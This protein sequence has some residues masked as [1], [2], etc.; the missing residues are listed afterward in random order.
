MLRKSILAF[1]FI[2]LIFCSCKG[3]KTAT[4]PDVSPHAVET[5]TTTGQPKGETMSMTVTSTAFAERQPI[6]TK[7]TGDAEDMSPALAWTAGPAG[8]RTYAIICD[9]PDAPTPQPWVHWVMYDIPADVTSL[10]EAVPMTATLPFGAVQGRS[11]FGRTGYG[12]P[13]PPS[14]TH[15]YYFKVYAIDKQLGLAPGATKAQVLSAMEGHVLAQG[16]LMG[17]YAHR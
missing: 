11:S 7:Y 5:A 6:P 13:K 10:T 16:V 9:D 2:L 12:G 3:G 8:T 17:T 15:R 14:G 4:A 1:V